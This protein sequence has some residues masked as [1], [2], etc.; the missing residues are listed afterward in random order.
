MG[1]IAKDTCTL[2][3]H[4]PLILQM[5]RLGCHRLHPSHSG[6]LERSR[7]PRPNPAVSKPRTQALPTLPSRTADQQDNTDDWANGVCLPQ[8]P[9]SPLKLRP[10]LNFLSLCELSQACG[11][12]SESPAWPE[13]S[14]GKTSPMHTKIQASAMNGIWATKI[15]PECVPISFLS[16]TH[17]CPPAPPLKTG[18]RRGVGWGWG[19][20]PRAQVCC[21]RLLKMCTVRGDP[22]RGETGRNSA[23]AP[24]S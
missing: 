21:V 9:G 16:V 20:V 22:L 23:C 17:S 6:Q 1:G 10:C 11:F 3:I 4:P 24:F 15:I 13:F 7:G 2:L 8:G 5:G 12:P 18:W 14:Q 19:C